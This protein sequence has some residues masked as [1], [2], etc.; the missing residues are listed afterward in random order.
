MDIPEGGEP[1]ET[2]EP[3]DDDG[4]HRSPEGP[5]TAT[6]DGA[7]PEAGPETTT[8]GE[9]E[10]LHRN[11]IRHRERN[12][13]SHVCQCVPDAVSGACYRGSLCHNRASRWECG[14]DCP[15]GE[16]CGNRAFGDRKKHPKVTV[17]AC[18]DDRGMG[19]FAGEPIARDRFIIEYIGEVIDASE[20][21]RRRSRYTE[22]GIEHFYFMEL[23]RG[24]YVD[25][26][27][28]ANAARFMNHACEPNCRAE[29]W[30]VSGEECIGLF[31][32]K[33]IREGEE[34]TW[35]YG[36]GSEFFRGKTCQCD[37]CR[38]RRQATP[39]PATT[40]SSADYYAMETPSMAEAPTPVDSRVQDSCPPG[41]VDHPLMHRRLSAVPPP[42]RQ[43]E[44]P[45]PGVL[46][47]IW[48]CKARETTQWRRGPD[49][50]NQ[51]CNT[52]GVKWAADNERVTKKISS[53]GWYE[54]LEAK[55]ARRPA[56]MAMAMTAPVPVPVSAIQAPESK[57]ATTR[58]NSRGWRGWRDKGAFTLKRRGGAAE[59]VV[60]D[61]I[62]NRFTEEHKTELIASGEELTVTGEEASRQLE[63][64]VQ[65]CLDD[66]IN[67][68]APDG[69]YTKGCELHTRLGF[70][71]H[72]ANTKSK[73][74]KCNACEDEWNDH[75]RS[76]VEND[77]TGWYVM[78]N[79]KAKTETL[80]R[81]RKRTEP[82]A[83]ETAGEA[84]AGEAA[85]GEAVDQD[86]LSEEYASE[87]AFDVDDEEDQDA[88]SE[89]AFDDE[90]A[91]DGEE[92]VLRTAPESSY[93]AAVEIIARWNELQ[94]HP[95]EGAASN[96][97][98]VALH[99]ISCMITEADGADGGEHAT[100]VYNAW[101]KQFL[102]RSVDYNYILP[103]VYE[104]HTLEGLLSF[105]VKYFQRSLRK[106]WDAST[107]EKR[108][109]EFF[110]SM[111]RALRDA[112]M[113]DAMRCTKEQEIR[114]KEM[115]RTV[116]RLDPTDHAYL[117]SDFTPSSDKRASS[118]SSPESSSQPD[119]PPPPSEGYGEL[120]MDSFTKVIAEVSRFATRGSSF[121]D[122][123]C[124]RGKCCF[125]WKLY[126]S[127]SE[128]LGIDVH[129]ERIAIAKKCAK[130]IG[131]SAS[132]VQFSHE[133]AA[134]ADKEIDFDIVY[135][136]DKVFTDE[137][138]R[139]IRARLNRPSS[140]WRV[141]VT[142]RKNGPELENSD[143]VSTFQI[144]MTGGRNQK[145]TAY[146]Y[147]K[148][149]TIEDELSTL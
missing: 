87:G 111:N 139:A 124:G 123:G 79:Y 9:Y 109:I 52:C 58:T 65:K 137:D 120:T 48:N 41:P 85:A 22:N 135:C 1:R 92:V 75:I 42:M 105:V 136:M 29:K 116:Q 32:D 36:C 61:D 70:K 35:N 67:L 50:P 90:E 102:L 49:G 108:D 33:D 27:K 20:L 77:D 45:Q 66:G 63:K 122:I 37:V 127:T 6:D 31:A 69:P 46:C 11:E 55:K 134:V 88:L 78:G 74:C 115:Y 3:R 94:Q 96:A 76:K 43:L 30:N 23:S 73:G 28:K 104:E 47:A 71:V 86:A 21:E 99:R 148:R 8:T 131:P 40:T 24:E 126:D 51:F 103:I 59:D 140:S 16:T 81:K 149:C 62:K 17:R 110:R 38:L 113:Y 125:H 119:S 82:T 15:C 144:S 95:T 97:L 89:E 101:V 145:H 128:V 56:A 44:V 7:G 5:E 121:L 68:R 98:E 132:T 138:L 83:G 91:F 12:T 118:S 143:L 25:A 34:L 133:N 80:K 147:R 129:R 117:T 18:G 53:D 26:T 13:E 10:E 19:L 57:R 84:A 72:S 142:F 100:A 130:Q 60:F 14:E 2:R 107:K 106:W 54:M 93:D 146:V 4:A 64:W 112:G 141:F 39:P 114:I